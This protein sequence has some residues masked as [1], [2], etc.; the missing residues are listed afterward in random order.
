MKRFAFVIIAGFLT[1]GC[2]DMTPQQ[3][4]AVMGTLLGTAVGA[5]SSREHRNRNALIGAGVG[6]AGGLLYGQQQ[7]RTQQYPSRRADDYEKWR[8]RREI[9]RLRCENER[10]QNK[11]TLTGRND[12][13]EVW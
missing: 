11:T 3:Q 5:M 2:A 7:Q 13:H 9:E 1:S 8:M 4:S 12:L 6:L 10:L